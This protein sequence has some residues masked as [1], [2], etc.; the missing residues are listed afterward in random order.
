[1]INYIKTKS[2]YL[3]LLAVIISF[4]SCEDII[5]IE[6]QDSEPKI[7]VDALLNVIEQTV[8]VRLSKTTPLYSTDTTVV[9]LD[10]NVSLVNANGNTIILSKVAVG[11]Y[12]ANDLIVEAGEDWTLVVEVEN[13]IY[14]GNA[15]VP[16]FVELAKVDTLQTAFPFGDTT[17]VFYQVSMEWFDVL[18][19]DNF[20]RLQ[21]YI[22]DTLQT[23]QYFLY[24]DTQNN[25]IAMNRPIMSLFQPGQNITLEL[26]STNESYYDFYLQVASIQEQ[27][28][29][30]TTPFNPQGN[31]KDSE[32]NTIL[33][34]FGIIQS[35]SINVQL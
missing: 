25:G 12:V 29:G 23:G 13:E 1:M 16:E 9:D 31:M 20:Y 30:G 14:S 10:A 15:I 18:D 26:Y 28:F 33:G 19:V 32:G 24:A 6:V 8:T 27:G 3:L 34:N 5:E 11:E 7:V 22:N 17:I 35:S 21:S 4:A 2:S